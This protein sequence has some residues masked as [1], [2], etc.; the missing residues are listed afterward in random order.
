RAVSLLLALV[1]ALAL[2][3]VAA[4]VPRRVGGATAIKVP[5]PLITFG[6]AML[7]EGAVSSDNPACRIGRRVEAQVRAPGD[8]HWTPAG[9]MAT[10]TDGAFSLPVSPAH[11]G[12]VRAVAERIHIGG[13]I[14]ARATAEPSPIEVAALVTARPVRPQVNAGDCARI[15]VTVRPAKPGA[16]VALERLQDGAWLPVGPALLSESS[17]A[18]VPLCTDFESIGVVPVRASWPGGVLN[19]PGTSA[20]SDVRVVPAP[21]MLRID[22]LVGDRQVSISVR[23][24]GRILYR[25]LDTV[26]RIPASN[27]KLLL[28][29]ALLD[30]VGPTHL[31]ETAAAAARVEDGVVPGDLW[32]LGGGNPHIDE[33][34]LARLAQEVAAAGIREIGGSV[35]GHTGPFARD[36][37]APG[38]RDY[39]PTYNIPLP[40]ALTFEGNRIPGKHVT[41]PERRAAKAFTRS[42]REAGIRVRGKPRVGPDPGDGLEVVARIHSPPLAEVLAEVNGESRNFDAEVLGKLLGMLVFDQPGTIEKGARAMAA[43]AAGHGVEVVAHDA[44]GLSYA[45]RMTAAG[46]ALLLDDAEEAEWGEALA[47]S[48]AVPGTG[49]LENRLEGVRVRAKTGTLEDISALSGY[50]WSDRSGSWIEFAILSADI[51]KADAR[52]IEDRVVKILSRL[53]R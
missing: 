15:S 38:W 3:S 26:S 36:W 40:T 16:A 44:S 43:F 27:Q 7:V 48:L 12:A 18:A 5:Q 35:R 30:E 32:L 39:F 10:D 24:D 8:S 28:S 21:W 31:L 45:N 20:P 9:T 37:F 51:R 1:V 47:T 6:D 4:T 50:V 33:D 2:G 53:A 19:L 11:S 23:D 22:R 46:L 42:L 49:T 34:E 29:M 14:C 41:D 17:T 52:D 13:V 25:H